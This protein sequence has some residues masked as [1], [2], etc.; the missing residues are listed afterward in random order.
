MWLVASC[1]FSS[2]GKSDATQLPSKSFLEFLAEMEE[3][4]GKLISPIDLL[5]ESKIPEPKSAT[6]AAE[7]KKKEVS[8][9][10]S[11][12]KTKRDKTA[13]QTELKEG[14]Q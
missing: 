1:S 6:K 4:D 11:E 9:P 7:A 14:Q 3:V 5:E 2:Y 13:T 10:K 12:T 8:V